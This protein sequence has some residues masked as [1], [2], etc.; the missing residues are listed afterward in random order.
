MLWIFLETHDEAPPTQ[1]W[2][3]HQVPH[4]L[5]RLLREAGMELSFD[6]LCAS[7]VLIEILP[8]MTQTAEAYDTPK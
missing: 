7:V 2:G 8:S 6:F 4:E 5:L 1:A 3:T